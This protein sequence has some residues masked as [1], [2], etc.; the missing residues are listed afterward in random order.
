MTDD[1][2]PA[3]KAADG[4]EGADLRSVNVRKGAIG[5]IRADEVEVAQGA[6]GGIM[7]DRVY[8]E[9]G[10]LG[11]VV[12]GKVSVEQGFVQGVIAGEVT[13]EQAGARTVMANHVTFGPS[14]GAIL[15]V[16]RT[17]D[18][19]GRFLL[20]WRGGLALGAAFAVVTAI[21]RQRR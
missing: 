21:L 12:A 3:S 10:A 20:D 7:A 9:R 17:V 2:M 5:Q 16:A 4:S 6:V 8:V 19:D 15:V 14:S 13:F 18:G 1:A 11:G